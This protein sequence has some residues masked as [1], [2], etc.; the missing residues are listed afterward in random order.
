MKRNTTTNNIDVVEIKS[1]PIRDDKDQIINDYNLAKMAVKRIEEYEKTNKK[2]TNIPPKFV[3]WLKDGVKKIDNGDFESM[4]DY[5]Q[6]TIQKTM[7]YDLVCA[8]TAMR[9]AKLEK[10]GAFKSKV[11]QQIRGVAKK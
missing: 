1:R 3:Q 5:K 4:N 7:D 10:Q 2:P 9:N 11:V 6:Q 8:N